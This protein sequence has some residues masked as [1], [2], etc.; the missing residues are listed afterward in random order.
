M[1]GCVCVCVC[2]GGCV[3]IT[4]T[5]P[6]KVTPNLHLTYIKNGD[7]MKWKNGNFSIKSYVVRSI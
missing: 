3:I 7:D 6:Y 1:G 2:V 5:F 4:E